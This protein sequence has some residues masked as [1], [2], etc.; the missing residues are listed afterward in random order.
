M[1][2]NIMPYNLS[3]L[4]DGLHALI[5]NKDITIEEL[6]K[7]VK[8]PD[9]PTGGIIYGFEGV[10]AGFETGRGRV[11][12]RGKITSETTKSGKGKADHLRTALPGEQGGTAPEDRPAGE[13]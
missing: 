4:V 7:H 5:D 13:R 8:A 11:V 10:K 2:T 6:I 12:V 1:A 3:E 9:F